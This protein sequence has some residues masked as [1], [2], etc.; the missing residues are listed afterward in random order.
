MLNLGQS[1]TEL[2]RAV[3]E[4]QRRFLIDLDSGRAFRDVLTLLVQLSGS[5]CGRLVR[6]SR[7][8]EGQNAIETVATVNLSSGEPFSEPHMNGELF[9]LASLDWSRLCE[10]LIR[11]GQALFFMGSRPWWGL[12]CLNEAGSLL[13]VV[14]LAIRRKIARKIYWPRYARFVISAE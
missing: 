14:G 1:A 10:E 4:I 13:G 2:M 5:G 3:V 7:Q 11:E 9:D 12:P 8:A 6:V